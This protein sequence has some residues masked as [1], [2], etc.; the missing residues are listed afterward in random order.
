M[1][2]SEQSVKGALARVREA[3]ARRADQAKSADAEERQRREDHAIITKTQERLAL[4]SRQEGIEADA[5]H[6]LEHDI[7]AARQKIS[8]WSASIGRQEIE[9]EEHKKERAPLAK[10]LAELRELLSGLDD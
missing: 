3:I 7:A 10:E 1:D 9:L 6:Q 5:I 8:E 4:V 2:I